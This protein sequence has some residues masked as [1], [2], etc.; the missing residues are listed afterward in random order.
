MTA[1]QKMR[2][3]VA[4]ACRLEEGVV[5]RNLEML[6]IRGI[7]LWL[8]PAYVA[9]DLRT[10]RSIRCRRRSHIC[11][12]VVTVTAQCQR[13]LPITIR[14]MDQHAAVAG[15]RRPT[16]KPLP[17]ARRKTRSRTECRSWKTVTSV[18]RKM[19]HFLHVRYWLCCVLMLHWFWCAVM[20]CW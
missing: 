18:S 9:S 20:P 16:R 7:S 2:W 6:P 13:W 11:M 3:K 14:R 15:R 17:A 5:R 1:W 8:D 4:T 12:A 10:T 19:D